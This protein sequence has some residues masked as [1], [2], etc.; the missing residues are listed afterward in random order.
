MKTE[1][2]EDGQNYVMTLKVVLIRQRHAWWNATCRCSTT[3]RAMTSYSTAP[4]WNTSPAV[5]CG[6]SSTC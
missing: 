4:I 3:A 2:R 6:S 5:V 1:F